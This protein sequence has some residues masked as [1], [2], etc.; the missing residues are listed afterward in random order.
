MT[1]FCRTN[2]RW[3]LVGVSAMTMSAHAQTV[4]NPLPERGAGERTERPG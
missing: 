2:N 3:A 1:H 4:T